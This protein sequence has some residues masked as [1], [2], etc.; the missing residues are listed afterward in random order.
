MDELL[1][2]IAA[3]TLWRVIVGG[4]AGGVVALLLAAAVPSFSAAWGFSV[5]FL[6]V[7]GGV[8]WQAVDSS[9]GGGPTDEPAM[10][11]VVAFLGLAFVGCIWGGLVEFATQSAWATAGI[12]LVSPLLFAPITV[13]VTKRTVSAPRLLCA[14]SALLVGFGVPY[15]IHALTASAGG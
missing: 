13:A 15:A 7:V 5:V 10:S 11:P 8:V 2:A 14:S 1:T 3:I 6:G 12:L 9:D 4:L